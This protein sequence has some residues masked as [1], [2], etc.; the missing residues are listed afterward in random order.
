MYWAAFSA[1]CLKMPSNVSRAHCSVCSIAFGKFFSVQI[2]IDFSGGSWDELYD[3]VKNGTT[4][5]TGLG[6]THLNI[7]ERAERSRLEQRLAVVHAAPIHV[8]TR[9]D[10]VQRVRH[11]VQAVEER[12]VVEALRFRPDAVFV[13]RHLNVAVHAL[14]GLGGDARLRLLHIVRPEQELPVQVALLDQ[15]HIGDDDFTV[16]LGRDPNHRKVLQ[17]LAADRT[18]PDDEVLQLTQHV[19]E[20]APEHGN[21]PIAFI[22]SCA[23]MPPIAPFIGHRS[24]AHTLANLVSIASFSSST[25]IS[26]ARLRHISTN[27]AASSTFQGRGSRPCCS[28]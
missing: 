22:T 1:T 6:T 26:L 21:L 3:S 17:Q 16:A 19:L 24:P 10:V 2:G 14:H 5:C 18:G 15:I 12:V 8:D 9:I 27:S 4:T 23:V 11:A 20:L 25:A 7:A 13:R 28:W